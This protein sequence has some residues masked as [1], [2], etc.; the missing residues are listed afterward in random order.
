MIKVSYLE[1]QDAT[2]EFDTEWEWHCVKVVPIWPSQLAIHG[3]TAQWF[4]NKLYKGFAAG[5]R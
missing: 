3:A 1:Q 2:L 4:L 5:C